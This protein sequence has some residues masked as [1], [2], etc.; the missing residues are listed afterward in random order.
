MLGP[1]RKSHTSIGCVVA[2]GQDMVV[3]DRL[4]PRP[5]E[6]SIVLDRQHEGVEGQHLP[7]GVADT[8]HRDKMGD[9]W[10]SNLAQSLRRDV[11]RVWLVLMAIRACE[12]LIAESVYVETN[13]VLERRIGRKCRE[14][15]I[16]SFGPI[17]WWLGVWGAASK[18]GCSDQGQGE[19]T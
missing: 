18:N 4:A 17:S 15:S 5:R 6:N 8:E 19:R 2:P 3:A 13:R 7:M 11:P 12:A 9:G 16:G 10:R 14:K 1:P